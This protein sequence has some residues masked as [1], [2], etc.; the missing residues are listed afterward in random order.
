[1]LF[2]ALD[3]KKECYKIFCDGSLVE[4]YDERVLTHTWSPTFHFSN[5]NIEYAQIWAKGATLDEI[6]PENLKSRWFSATERAK[7]FLKT[8]QNAKINLDDVCFYDLLPEDFLLDF[9]GAKN[10]ICKFVFEN[11]A[12]PKNYDFLKDLVLLTK[13]IEQ[14][15]VIFD[16]NDIKM[17]STSARNGIKK[18]R[19]CGRKVIYNPW[20]A[21]T[22]RLTTEGTSF[23]ILTLNKE[24]RA[25]IK[26]QN[27]VF[28]ELD[29]NAAEIRVLLGLLDQEQP[30]KDIHEWINS[31]VFNGKYDREQT[32][33]KVFAWLYNPEASNKKLN[34]FL[35]RDKI[36]EK[37]FFDDHVLT[38]FYRRIPVD[39]KKALNYLVQ[40]TSS[41]MLL[42]SAMKINKILKKTDSFVAFCIHDSIIIDMSIEDKDLVDELT[43]CF[44][45]TMFGKLKVNL[46]IGRNFGNMRTIL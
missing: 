42:S 46:S 17:S 38:P 28:V 14:Q 35:D 5:T 23:P 37:Y 21:V 16:Y 12:R 10:Q 9:Y 34:Q 1:M 39:R 2:Q 33:K 20:K 11:Y 29:Y 8:F 7:T 27:D 22:G 30:E 41:D 45:D 15:D 24:L 25:G 18:L 13:T 40:S 4:D 43:S 3:N 44:S 26:P 6:C 19:G 32:K 31:N 36:Y